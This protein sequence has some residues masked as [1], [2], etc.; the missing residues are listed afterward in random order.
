MD[1]FFIKDVMWL[2]QNIIYIANINIY[3]FCEW[4]IQDTNFIERMILNKV[5]DDQEHT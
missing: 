5:Y 2:I 3:E 4:N 1:Q